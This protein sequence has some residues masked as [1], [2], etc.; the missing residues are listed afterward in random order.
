M[1]IKVNLGFAFIM[2]VSCGLSIMDDNEENNWVPYLFGTATLC[3]LA[4]VAGD[5]AKGGRGHADKQENKSKD[6][7]FDIM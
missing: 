6:D 3:F 5:S 2:A 4:V 1:G 7:R